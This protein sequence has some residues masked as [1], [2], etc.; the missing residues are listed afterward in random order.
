VRTPRQ[1]LQQAP[2]TIPDHWSPETA[3]AVFEMIDEL[4]DQIWSKD[5]S[6]IQDELCRQLEPDQAH[7]SASPPVLDL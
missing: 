6:A 4:R 2:P 1:P 7:D 3:L 5:A